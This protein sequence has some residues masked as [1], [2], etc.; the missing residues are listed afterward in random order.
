VK[1]G[2]AKWFGQ[3]EVAGDTPLSVSERVDVSALH[4]DFAAK[5]RV[6][7]LD[8]LAAATAQRLLKCLAQETPWGLASIDQGTPRFTPQKALLELTPEAQSRLVRS[9]HEAA[10]AGEYQYLYHCY[11]IL[12][13][14]LESWNPSLYLNRWLEFV[15]TEPMLGLV[16]DVTGFQDLAKADAQASFFAPNNFLGLHNDEHIGHGWRVA[17]VMNFAPGWREDFG[18]ALT[19]FDESGDVTDAF[20]PRY[21]ALYL[22]AVPQRHSVSFVAPFAPHGRFAISGWFR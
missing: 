13:A 3:L 17:Y 2:Q 6:K 14:Y 21:N 11:P 9:A 15:N 12:Q 20:L 10:G 5:R 4:A 7:I 8:C 1:S 18:G 19:F 16:R 22:F